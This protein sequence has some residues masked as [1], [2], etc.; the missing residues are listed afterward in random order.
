MDENLCEITMDIAGAYPKETGLTYYQRITAPY[1]GHKTTIKE[2][3]ADNYFFTPFAPDKLALCKIL[4]S[5]D[6]IMLFSSRCLLRA[7]FTMSSSS[8]A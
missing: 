6:V 7:S 5:K 1:K 3:L 8:S 2:K 4:L